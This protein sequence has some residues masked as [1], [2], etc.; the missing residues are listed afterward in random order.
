MFSKKV[1]VYGA[2]SWGTALANHA[3]TISKNTY[4][5]SKNPKVAYE[6]NNEH[7][8][9]YFLGDI[10]LHDDL[11]ATSDLSILS[12][13]DII[14]IAVPSYAFAEVMLKIK[15]L[16][17]KKSS[18]IMIATKGITDN[19]VQL[20]SDFVIKHLTNPFAFISGPNFAAEVAKGLLASV[21]ISSKDIE[22]ARQLQFIFATEK[23]EVSIT[24]DI[25]TQQIAGIVKNIVAIKSG[26]L[27]AKGEGE[28]ARAA[29]LTK[30]LR[31]IAIIST[32]LGGRFETI[33][34]PAVVGD[35]VL[36]GYSATSR[37]TKF[38]YALHKHDYS[39]EFIDNY[40]ILVEGVE[41]ARLIGKLI[42]LSAL[43]LPV[44][45][46]VVNHVR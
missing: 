3:T 41:A 22:L 9:S 13:A 11:K 17:I 12:D 39:K 44:I 42:D 46:A 33:L 38:G 4:I 20:F 31:E 45:S 21:T 28:N 40:P 8:N 18:I 37:N 16:S 2:G 1:V 7:K 32:Q 36:T 14:I 26:I 30:G 15:E 29:L 6:I 35:L 25:I 23:L 34:E 24:D 27:S 19:P 5:Y 43:D 10:L